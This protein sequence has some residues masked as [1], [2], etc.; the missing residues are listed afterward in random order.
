MK[1]TCAGFKKMAER[2]RYR[3]KVF[4]S[5]ILFKAA[6]QMNGRLHTL[7]KKEC[8]RTA[9][10]KVFAALMLFLDSRPPAP[11]HMGGGLRY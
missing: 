8:R 3:E 11:S 1:D 7:E 6:A 10:N 5:L 9:Y 4:A 2:H